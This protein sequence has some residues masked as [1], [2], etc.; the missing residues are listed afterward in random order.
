MKKDHTAAIASLQEVVF[1]INKLSDEDW[2]AFAQIW[3]PYHAKRKE[4]MSSAGKTERYLY[5]VLD[6]VQRVYYADEQGRDATIV[7]TFYPSF[8][9]VIDSLLLQQPSKYYYEALTTSEF[10][11]APYNE[12]NQL[13]ETRPAIEWMIRQGITAAFSGVMERLVELQIL[14]SEEKFKKLLT[15]SPHILQRVPQK[16]LANYLGIDATNFSKLMNKLMI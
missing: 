4:I 2:N 15:R 10:I 14:S 6:G 11:R 7:F 8:G 1:S 5:F 12:L 3:E 9:G 16:Y 13:M